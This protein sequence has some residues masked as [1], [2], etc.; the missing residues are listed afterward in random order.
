MVRPSGATAQADTSASTLNV[1]MA[2]PRSTSH[3]RTILSLDPE[4]AWE[5]HDDTL[6]QE[7]AKTAHFCSMCGPRFCSMKITQEVRDYAAAHGV[8]DSEAIERGM[9]EKAKEFTASGGDVYT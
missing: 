8:V 1:A 5:Y 3:T 4:T 6:P 7:G 9:E 2:S